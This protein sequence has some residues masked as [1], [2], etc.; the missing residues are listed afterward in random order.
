MEQNN[1]IQDLRVNKYFGGEEERDKIRFVGEDLMNGIIKIDKLYKTTPVKDIV[2]N[3]G[4]VHIDHYKDLGI[5]DIVFKKGKIDID[6]IE[7]AFLD[8]ATFFE[9]D[10]QFGMLRMPQEEFAKVWDKS[11]IAIALNTYD[12]KADFHIMWREEEDFHIEEKYFVTCPDML[13]QISET[14]S[15]WAV[16]KLTKEQL[17]HHLTT[18]IALSI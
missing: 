16:R 17:I 15:T 8:I 4:E 18:Y 2:A 10:L 7:N 9:K 12:G 14:T 1:Y 3:M 6:K 5:I 13:E 11:K